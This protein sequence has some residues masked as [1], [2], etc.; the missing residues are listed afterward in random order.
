MH[1]Y[2]ENVDYL[3]RRRLRDLRQTGLIQDYVKMFIMI[4]LDICDMM[5]KDNL[6]FFLN[7][8]SCD[9]AM[10]LQRRRVQNLV[11]AIIAVE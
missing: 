9:A 5:E 10:D 8:L 11:D 6:F 3:A 2:P 1:F 4:M 7:G